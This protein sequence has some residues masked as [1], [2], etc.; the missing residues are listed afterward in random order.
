MR[1]RAL[2]VAG[3]SLPAL[4]IG[5]RELL[6]ARRADFV[7]AGGGVLMTVATPELLPVRDGE[8]I[9]ALESGFATT[10]VF[11]VALYRSGGGRPLVSRRRVVKLQWNPWKERFTVV[12]RDDESSP[13]TA[14][15]AS[16]D[17]AV[18]RAT[19]LE[20]LRVADADALERGPQATYFVTVLAQRNPIAAGALEGTGAGDRAQGRDLAVFSRWIGI[21]VSDAPT[22][23]KTVGIRTAP[24]FYLVRR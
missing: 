7:E 13:I 2:L 1:R 16:R 23:E 24:A 11:E 17:D 19:S 22:A 14:S 21:F 4:A 15:F 3:L 8:V 10:L 12:I 20:R 5:G 6:R 18:A 9:R